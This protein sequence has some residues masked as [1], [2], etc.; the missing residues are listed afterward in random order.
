MRRLVREAW[1]VVLVLAAWQ[2]W[3]SHAGF[4]RI[5]LVTPAAVMRDLAG[6]PGAYVG[7]ALHTL[8]Y[9]LGGL[10]LGMLAG[11]FLA[12]V[13]N[14]S[15][16]LAGMVTPFSL[17]LSST[18][19]VC[20]IPLLARLFGYDSRSELATV[21]VMT[22]FPCYLYASRGL[23]EWPQLSD[24]VFR[25]LAA[26]RSARLRLLSLPAAM[27]AISSA[28]RLGASFSVL[29]ALVTEYL[30]QVGGLGT[31]FAVT[32]Q[33]FDMP[34]ALGASLI[35]MLLSVLLYEFG[36]AVESR[37]YRHYRG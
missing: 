29:V 10:A 20:L 26:T 6:A 16:L 27:P 30:I 33:K 24:E 21:A 12:I 25:S 32:M 37:I 3:A 14:L 15:E 7:P 36:S 9:A 11:V 5:V 23:L 17:V 31:L 13:A 1:P 8:A 4:N 35:A 34:R 2:I 28:L 19:V 18:P 22:F